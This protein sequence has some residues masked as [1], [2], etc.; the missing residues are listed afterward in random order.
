MSRRD[1]SSPSSS[2]RKLRAKNGNARCSLLGRGM[3]WA[4]GILSC[5]I[6]GEMPDV[7]S[8]VV[9]GVPLLCT[10]TCTT[11]RTNL[12]AALQACCCSFQVLA[13]QIKII[14]RISLFLFKI[15]SLLPSLNT[16]T[17]RRIVN[18]LILYLHKRELAF[19]VHCR[20][21][22][23][24]SHEL[25]IRVYISTRIAI[26]ATSRSVIVTDFVDEVTLLRASTASTS[27]VSIAGLSVVS[28]PVSIPCR[29]SLRFRHVTPAVATTST[30]STA[31]TAFPSA[32]SSR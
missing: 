13:V 6:G 5:R 2:S 16:T 15:L 22:A 20:P 27:T 12:L 24:P 10:L 14:E 1:S 9:R 29:R 3:E 21:L 26:L 23:L 32:S 30:T 7:S 18:M 31:A 28:V 11:L 8:C 4:V 17:R 19:P 25:G